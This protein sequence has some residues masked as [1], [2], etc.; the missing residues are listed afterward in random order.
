MIQY[1]DARIIGSQG[2]MFVSAMLQTGELFRTYLLGN[3]VE[4]FDIY[5]EVNDKTYPFPFLVQVKTTD[6]NNR[7]NIHGIC[8]PV[9]DEKLK[10]LVDRPI[11]TYVA[12]FDLRELKMYLAPAFNTR[13]TYKNGIPIGHELNLKSRKKTVQVLSQMKDDI[14]IYW[15]N[16]DATN[17][18]NNYITLL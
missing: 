17:Y 9:S 7:Y 14:M 15:Q 13:V 1:H 12:G 6:L 5:V 11:P 4:V 3:C 18:K 10:W 16:L 8:T 2:E